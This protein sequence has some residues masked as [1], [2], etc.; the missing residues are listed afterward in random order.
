[1]HLLL[2]QVLVKTQ[3]ILI[4]FLKEYINIYN[5]FQCYLILLPLQTIHVQNFE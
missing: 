3:F 5:Y 2:F 4:I 1:M